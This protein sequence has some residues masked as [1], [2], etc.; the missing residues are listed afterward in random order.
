M[1]QIDDAGSGSLLGGTLIG[2]VRVETNEYAHEIIPLEYY[3]GTNFENKVYIQYVLTIIKRLFKS[4]HVSKEEEIHMCRGY[5]FDQAK[6]WLKEEQY[7]FISTKIQDPL[8]SIIEK[9]FE[10]YTISLGLPLNMI[11]Y[12]KYPFHFHR[13]LKWIYADYQI[14]SLLCKTGWKSWK[15]Y[16]NLEISIDR[17]KI[18]NNHLICLKCHEI[19]LKD[20][21]AAV[22]KYHST[23]LN[24]VFLH[25]D[26][27]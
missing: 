21:F 19:I 24:K 5:M 1:I 25:Q 14:R 23:R 12:T 2:I 26:C 9:E 6:V 16:G 8:Q 10:K 27:I 11:T 7:H 22:K 4:L 3:R 18:K 13:I 17:E 20:S 15:K